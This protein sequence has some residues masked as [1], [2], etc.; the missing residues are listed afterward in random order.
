[1]TATKS[2]VFAF[3]DITSALTAGIATDR[4]NVV[5]PFAVVGRVR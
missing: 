3:A 1:M 4:A 2:Y 5:E